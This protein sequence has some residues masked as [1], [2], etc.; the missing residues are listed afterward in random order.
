[1]AAR[2]YYDANPILGSNIPQARSMASYGSSPPTPGV[3]AYYEKRQPP[4]GYMS[5][6]QGISGY[7]SSEFP[8]GKV[9]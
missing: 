9:S 2:E 6:S 4:S 7:S 8:P 5:P 3:S 1:M